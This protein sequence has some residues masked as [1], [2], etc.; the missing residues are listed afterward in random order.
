MVR[1]HE[2]LF[3]LFVLDVSGK[4]LLAEQIE[5]RLL[6]PVVCPPAQSRVPLAVQA[7]LSS[8]GLQSLVGGVI[9]VE[10]S[11]GQFGAD[12]ALWVMILGNT[13]RLSTNYDWI[14]VEDLEDITFLLPFQS[15]IPRSTAF[16]CGLLREAQSID[17][18]REW[19]RSAA[20]AH[21]RQL[22]G[23][24]TQ[25]RIDS[26]RRM[27]CFL[28]SNSSPVYCVAGSAA[29]DEAN[30]AHWLTL[31]RPN[32]F[33]E[34]LAYDPESPRWLVDSSV[35]TPLTESLTL[36][37][38]KKAISKL[39]ALQ[40]NLTRAHQPSP[41]EPLR[42][43][44]LCSLA[45]RMRRDFD[46]LLEALQDDGDELRALCD[47][48]FSTLFAVL[49]EALTLGIPDSFVHADAAPPNIFL[50][51]EEVRLI[52]L[53]TA[54]WGF[55]FITA[56]TLLRSEQILQ[57]PHWTEDLTREYCG[58]WM[59]V[60]SERQVQRGMQLTPVIRVWAKLRDLLDSPFDS[61][62]ERYWHPARYEYLLVNYAQKL[63]RMT[64]NCKSP[65]LALVSQSPR[66]SRISKP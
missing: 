63:F 3:H 2:G 46:Q 65:Q 4:F 22:T 15:R 48:V 31:H 53:E 32:C 51:E 23:E 1:P 21:G 18:V 44:R 9:K 13:E 5:A 27:S 16:C 8:L 30:L 59:K 26:H 57:R 7:C 33:P 45:S 35:G 38:C 62:P 12:V 52:D 43:F 50:Y 14:S 55:P 60:I 24:F 19:A 6:L 10:D 29:A 54:G 41:L 17:S 49:T 61:A 58:P 37:D 36:D 56:E 40:I 39:A 47:S 20:A 28:S 11:H 64:L 66:Q 42:D 25:F 34:T